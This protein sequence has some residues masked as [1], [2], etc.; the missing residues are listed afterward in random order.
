MNYRAF[1]HHLTSVPSQTHTPT[2]AAATTTTVNGL[3]PSS[4]WGQALSQVDMIC[5]AHLPE[6]QIGDWLMFDDMGAYTLALLSPFNGFVWPH[7]YYY[8][9]LLCSSPCTLYTQRK[10]GEGSY[11]RILHFLPCT[12][13]SLPFHWIAM[14][15]DAFCV[16]PVYQF[17]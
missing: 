16:I 15:A 6:L 1:M 8:A 5:H 12:Y 7:I 10:R 17:F 13:A 2:S 14:N 9:S 4:L 11:N 3:H